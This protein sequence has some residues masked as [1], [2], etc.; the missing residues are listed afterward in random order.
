M[1]YLPFDFCILG[2]EMQTYFWHPLHC[3]YIIQKGKLKLER[4]EKPPVNLYRAGIM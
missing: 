1:S 2:K 3:I 4:E